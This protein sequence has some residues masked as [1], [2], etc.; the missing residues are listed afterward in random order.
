MKLRPYQSEASDNFYDAL[1]SGFNPVVQAP[2]GS[3]KSLIIADICSRVTKRGGRVVVATHVQELVGQNSKT[4]ERYTGQ[5]PGIVSAGLGENNS[6]PDVVF[7]NIQSIYKQ[8]ERFADRDLILVDEAHLVPPDGEGIM[9]KSFIQSCKA[10]AGGFT[11]TPW[12][13]DGGVIYGDGK[14]FDLLC[15][16]KSP[17]ELVDEGWLAPLIGVEAPWQLDMKNITK[18]AG[19]FSQ[20]S[21][22]KNMGSKWLIEV[23]THAKEQ[24]KGRNHGLIFAPTVETAKLI[25][26]ILIDHLRLTCGIVTGDCK[27]REDQLTAWKA[28]EVRFMV[29]VEVLVAGFDFPALDSIIALRPTQSSALWIQ[30]LGRGMRIADGKKNCLVLD[31][32]GNL[33]RLGG[34]GVMETWEK[35]LTNGTKQTVGLKPAAPTKVKIA[36]RTYGLSAIDPMLDSKDGLSVRVISCKYIVRPSKTPK[37]NLLIAV[38]ET[39]TDEGFSVSANSF[40]CVEHKGGA[41]WHADQWFK[42]RGCR[43]V[44]PPNAEAARQ[45]CYGLPVPR[46]LRLRRDGQY[47]NVIKEQF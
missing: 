16:Q 9:Y 36:A 35:Q 14:L 8:G 23:L 7:A 37:V 15:Y 13:L 3:G 29:N 18:T 44:I 34:V 5:A 11:A 47:M 43:E 10:R 32:V 38:F 45:I 39:E 24:L 26:T 28:G 33:Q 17:I 1:K 46:M 19:D 30:S 22:T 20:G 12:R 31:Y 21:V 4:Y 25:Q 2:T 27:D 41:R 42:S 40:I 6:A